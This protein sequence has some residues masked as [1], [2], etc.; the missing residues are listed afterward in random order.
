MIE[1]IFEPNADNWRKQFSPA[2]FVTCG[3]T[4]LKFTTNCHAGQLEVLICNLKYYFNHL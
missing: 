2:A 1:F 3:Q 4:T